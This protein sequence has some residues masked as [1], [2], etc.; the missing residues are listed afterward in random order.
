MKMGRAIDSC[1]VAAYRL[2]RES[3]QSVIHAIGMLSAALMFYLVD[4]VAILNY[5]G[6]LKPIGWGGRAAI[7]AGGLCISIVALAIVFV[8]RAARILRDASL[9]SSRYRPFRYA[10]FCL[11]AILFFV[12]LFL[13]IRFPRAM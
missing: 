1:F 5:A 12:I 8:P 7:F 13:E 10:F 9:E 11:P 2:F 4:A 3:R 6:L